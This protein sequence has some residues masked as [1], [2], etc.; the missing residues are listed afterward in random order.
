[1]PANELNKGIYCGLPAKSLRL[2]CTPRDS[3]APP[4]VVVGEILWSTVVE[5]G[6]VSEGVPIRNHL[7]PFF[8]IQ[9]L[10]AVTVNHLGLSWR[11]TAEPTL[12]FAALLL[13]QSAAIDVTDKLRWN[14]LF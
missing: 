1:M 6:E 10:F 9:S 11:P 14:R 12:G 5:R 8:Q 7:S 4:T 13:C 3:F 2:S